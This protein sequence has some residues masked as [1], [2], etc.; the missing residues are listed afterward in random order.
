MLQ[1]IV[2]FG[3]KIFLYNTLNYIGYVSVMIWVLFNIRKYMS[4]CTFPVLL[5]DK[6]FKGKKGKPYRIGLFS[7]LESIIIFALAIVSISPLNAPLSNF[8]LGDHSDGFFPIIYFA[9]IALFILGVL[10]KINP[11][12][13]L[14]FSA[15]ADCLL[16]IIVKLACFFY[17][18]CYGVE[19]ATSFYYNLKTERY[20]IP[21]ALI[22]IICAVIMFV[23][24]SIML[25]KKKNNGFLYP[26]FIAMYS[27]S[28][29]VSEF[30]RDD[31]PETFGNLK[32]NQ[33]MC[34]IGLGLGIIYLIV[35]AICG[36]RVSDFFENSNRKFIEKFT[37]KDK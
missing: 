17:G 24:L 21:I 22:E 33:V 18:C 9:P 19:T 28:R 5:D 11:L 8:F 13:L 23:I 27:G 25:A 1:S 12:K 7:F 36:K 2:L 34:L 29:F 14:D 26:A 6:L 37:A 30:W 32:G 31:Y 10:I 3:H 4:F 35:V 15:P 16:L 20:E